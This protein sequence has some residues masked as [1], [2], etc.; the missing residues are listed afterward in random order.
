MV[1]G[2]INVKWRVQLLKW[3]ILIIKGVS[4]Q[5]RR[6]NAMT[7]PIPII[8]MLLINQSQLQLIIQAPDQNLHWCP[9]HLTAPGL[10]AMLAGM[11][12]VGLS[13]R[14]RSQAS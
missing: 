10:Q 8:I 4:L 7:L 1:F 11:V 3:G 2:M 14:K 5:T 9:V 6:K 13:K 12:R